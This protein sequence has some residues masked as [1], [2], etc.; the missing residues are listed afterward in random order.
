MVTNRKMTT[1]Y[2]LAQL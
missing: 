1:L 2:Q